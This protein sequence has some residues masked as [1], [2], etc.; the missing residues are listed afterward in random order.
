MVDHLESMGLTQIMAAVAGLVG[1]APKYGSR[2][3]QRKVV[4]HD[5]IR[6]LDESRLC[7]IYSPA[8]CRQQK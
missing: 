2:R 4:K 3:L 6:I 5:G 7:W 1:L 8:Q